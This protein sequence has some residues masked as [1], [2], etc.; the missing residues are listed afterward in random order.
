VLRGL[1]IFFIDIFLQQRSYASWYPPGIGGRKTVS[2]NMASSTHTSV[3]GCRHGL[4]DTI[5]RIRDPGKAILRTPITCP[6]E[7]K[8]VIVVGS[9]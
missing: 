8:N 3:G 2:M 6:A 9:S 5:G 7:L 1:T 4:T